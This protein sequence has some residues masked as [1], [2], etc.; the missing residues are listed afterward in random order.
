MLALPLLAL[1]LV[2]AAPQGPSAKELFDS[3]LGRLRMSQQKDGSYGTEASTA[4]AVIAMA[5]GPRAYREDDGPFVREA[6]RYL[7]AATAGEHSDPSTDAVTA[8]AL[9]CVAGDRYVQRIQALSQRA[10]VPAGA[11]CC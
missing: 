9:Q 3:N 7:L 4:H 5:L 8:L 10:G 6:V 2:T 11:I 1:S